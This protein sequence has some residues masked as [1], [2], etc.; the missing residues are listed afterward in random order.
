MATATLGGGAYVDGERVRVRPASPGLRFLDVCTPQQRWWT[1]SQRLAFNAL[2]AHGVSLAF[3]DTSGLEYIE[4]AAG[5][6]GVMIVTWENVWDHA[7]GLLLH[8]EA[9]GV[10]RTAAGEP[11]RLAGGNMLPLVAA[12]DE[13]CAARVHAAMAQL[14]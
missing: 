4:L 8:A 10:A 13:E 2:C 1:P 14:A 7:A 6:R 3:F 9:G 11:F 12:P 5:R